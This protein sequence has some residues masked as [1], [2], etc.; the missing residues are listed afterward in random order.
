MRQAL[1]LLVC[2]A[3]PAMAQGFVLDQSLRE[4]QAERGIAMVRDLAAGRGGVMLTAEAIFCRDLEGGL[5]MLGT[6]LTARD[7]SE[8]HWEVVRGST[9]GV[10][11]QLMARKGVPASRNDLRHE[12]SILL[13]SRLCRDVLAHHVVEAEDLLRVETLNGAQRLSELAP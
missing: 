13:D 11:L 7:A 9:G 10:A 12:L 4:F 8:E 3:M 6:S 1:A 2:A 5:F